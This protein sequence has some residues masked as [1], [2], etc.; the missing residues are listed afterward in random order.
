MVNGLRNS[1]FFILNS[2]FL[3]FLHSSFI[4]SPPKLT[5]ITP[6]LKNLVLSLE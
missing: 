2:S 6:F 4:K 3:I 1:S 5:N